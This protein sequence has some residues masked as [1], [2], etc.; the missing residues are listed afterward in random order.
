MSMSNYGSTRT[1]RLA[2]GTRV[3]CIYYE[4]LPERVSKRTGLKKP[5]EMRSHIVTGTV[6]SDG[7]HSIYVRTEKRAKSG[8]W[9]RKD[10]SFFPH[11]VTVDSPEILKTFRNPLGG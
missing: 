7:G 8:R 4:H 2:T 6:L 11:E 1:E 9:Y 10:M 3:M 5:A